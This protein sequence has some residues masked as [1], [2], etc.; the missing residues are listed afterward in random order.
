MATSQLNRIGIEYE[1]AFTTCQQIGVSFAFRKHF[2]LTTR[3]LALFVRYDF[4]SI[5][6]E[7]ILKLTRL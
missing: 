7:S 1:V 2:D 6:G 3:E 5:A 4:N